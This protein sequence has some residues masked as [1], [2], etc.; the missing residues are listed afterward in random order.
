[1]SG[2]LPCCDGV[3]NSTLSGVSYFNEVLISV[4]F[5]ER[6]GMSGLDIN[7]GEVG[8]YL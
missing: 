5:R 3:N 6:A 8:K 7:K 4:C 1:M 2:R